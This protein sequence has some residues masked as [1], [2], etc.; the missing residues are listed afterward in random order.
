M[1]KDKKEQRIV[2]VVQEKN[3]IGCDIEKAFHKYMPKS[4]K[5]VLIDYKGIFPSDLPL[6]LLLVQ[7]GH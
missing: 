5:V 4:I 7:M 3:A 1:V 6:G 2:P